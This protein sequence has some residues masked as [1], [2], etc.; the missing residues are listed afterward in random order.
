MN[1]ERACVHEWT[2]VKN[3]KARD[4]TVTALTGLHIGKVVKSKAVAMKCIKCD[5]VRLHINEL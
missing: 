2:R 5:D 3:V 4:I 1:R